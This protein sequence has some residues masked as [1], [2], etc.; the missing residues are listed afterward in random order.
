[1]KSPI[2][3]WTCVGATSLILMI[4]PAFSGATAQIVQQPRAGTVAAA[5]GG[6][7][8]MWMEK[9]GIP[10]G[11]IAV[12][13]NDRLV[14]A[15]GYGDRGANDRVAVWSLSKAVTALCVASLVQDKKLR[16]DDAINP[17]LAPL[18]SKHGQPADERL[19]QVTVAQLLTHRSGL[20]E[21]VGNNRFAPGA[22]ELLQHEPLEKATAEMLMA[23]IMGLHLAAEPGSKHQYSNVGYLLLGQVIET[24]TGNAYETECGQRVLGKAGIKQPKLDEN[25]VISCTP[26][27]VGR[28]RDPNIS[29]SHGCCRQGQTDS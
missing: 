7:M 9:Y 20:P 27:P 17:L 25:G 21:N 1:M 11:S 8:R 19:G 14:F 12:M 6:A 18:F 3:R 16:L 10:R 15:E 2:R 26:P 4:F 29:R 13:R 24:V 22:I 28:Y 23:P 5:F